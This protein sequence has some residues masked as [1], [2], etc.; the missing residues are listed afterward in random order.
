MSFSVI[1]SSMAE[2]MERS[3]GIFFLTLIFSLPLGFLIAFGRMSKNKLLQ[4][5]ARFNRERRY[6]PWKE[7]LER[8]VLVKS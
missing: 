1:L 7:I 2:G 4:A 6:L 8:H 5:I 3:V